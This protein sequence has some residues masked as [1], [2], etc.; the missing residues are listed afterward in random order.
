MEDKSK[1]V[2]QFSKNA[3]NEIKERLKIRTH[4]S[5]EM[6]LGGVD[7]MKSEDAVIDAGQK[8]EDSDYQK[9][10]KP[11]DIVGGALFLASDLSDY[12]TGQVIFIDGGRLA[13]G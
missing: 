5:D 2:G 13:L 12:M 4:R 7:D 9:L 10:G 1:L 8:H 6:E 11:E 3:I